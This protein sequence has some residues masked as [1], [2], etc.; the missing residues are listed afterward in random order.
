MRYAREDHHQLKDVEKKL[1]TASDLLQVNFHVTAEQ[2]TSD[3]NDDLLE[4]VRLCDVDN[5]KMHFD[6]QTQIRKLDELL[7]NLVAEAALAQRE[8]LRV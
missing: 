6:T 4:L 2:Q 5:Q 7:R 8:V 1:A 3:F